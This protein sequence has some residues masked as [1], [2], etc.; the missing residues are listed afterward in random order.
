MNSQAMQSGTTKQENGTAPD[1]PFSHRSVHGY[2]T[3][4]QRITVGAT[5]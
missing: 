3:I 5:A 4:D 1:G 2:E